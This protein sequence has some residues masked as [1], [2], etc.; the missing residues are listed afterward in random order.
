MALGK[1]PK[2]GEKAPAD[3]QQAAGAGGSPEEN[4]MSARMPLTIHAQYIRDLSFENP[5][6]PRSL[7]S[8][9][10]APQ[11]DINFSMDARRIEDGEIKD[12]YEVGLGVYITAKR[13]DKTAF[14]CELE[15]A[16]LCS[17]HEVPEEHVH[18]LL[19]IEMPRYAFPFVRQLVANITQQAG[20]TSLMLA[21]VD[22]RAFYMQ[23]Y[24]QP[25]AEPLDKT[26]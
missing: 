26:A 16:V 18:P 15:Y 13:G 22:F 20:F 25:P 7:R 1:K 24:G 5:N 6:A 23:R 3:P 4:A 9:A 12:L 8:D 10:G 17:L 2:K 21:P 19:L 14:I 11:M